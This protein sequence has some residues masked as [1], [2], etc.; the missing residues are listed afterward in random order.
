MV[1]TGGAVFGGL[2][3]LAAGTV[4]AAATASGVT[5]AGGNGQGSAA[6]QFFGPAGVFVDGTGNIYVADELNHR[7]QEWAPGATAGVTVAGGNGAGPAANQLNDPFGVFVDGTGN[8][9]VADL[10]NNR[11]QEWAPGAT[12]GVTVAGGNGQGSAAN[13]V[14]LPLAVFVDGAAN[15]YVADQL[16]NRVQEWA[17]G[18]T[19]GV[20]VAGGNGQGS[21]A[22]Q[23]IDPSGVVVDGAGNV[24]V[25]DLG[26]G[27]VQ[28]WAPGATAGV[29]VAGGNGQGSAANQ[30]KLPYG[31]FVDGSG[32][33]YVADLVNQR[34]QEWAPGAT[35]GVTVA[36][37]NGPGSAANQLENPDGVFVDGAGDIYVDDSSNNRIQEWKLAPNGQPLVT[38]EPTSQSA[39]ETRDASFT[40]GANGRPLPTVQ[41]QQSTDGGSTWTDISGAT[42]GT[43][44]LTNALASENGFEFRAVFTNAAGSATT[45]AATLTV[46]PPPPTT[47]V[48]LPSNGATVSN[49]IWLDAVASSP[50]GIASVSYEVSGGPGSITDK[51]VSSSQRW[52][53]GYLGAWDTTDVPNG[54]YTL[55]SVAIDALGNST[56]SAPVTVTVDNLPLQTAVLVPS[57]GATLSGSSAVL[58]ASATGTSDVTSVQFEVTGGTL[59][60]QVV[61]T[62]TLALWGWYAFWNTTTVPNGTYTLQSVATEAGGTSAASPPITVTVSN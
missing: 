28:K 41:W 50:V 35:A 49:S 24:Y 5:V 2:F 55:Q 10:G 33:I 25:D 22:D 13:Q 44:T 23:F 39:P 8:V 36:G 54:T 15:V 53:Y 51:L 61:G 18:A 46:L 27:R 43:Y 42:S 30:L 48:V 31:L 20:T 45:N 9:Y 11:V 38:A 19:A 58:D 7:V 1:V 6:N 12:A 37:G 29:T 32:N 62:A 4:A 26:N 60:K 47:S 17:P 57:N 59:S 52:I 16:N 3:D 21:A 56:T 34:V 40:A 14:G